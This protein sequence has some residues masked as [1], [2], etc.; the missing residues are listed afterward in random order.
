M[1]YDSRYNNNSTIAVRAMCAIVFCV[2]TFVWLYYFQAD[3][4][5]VGQHV[6]SGGKTHYN[7]L[8]GALLITFVLQLMQQGVYALVRLQ[9]RTHALTYVPSFLVLAILS[10]LAADGGE[11]IKPAVWAWL[12]PL[13]LVLWGVAVWLSRKLLPFESDKGYIGLFSRR[14]WIN[15]LIMAAQIFTAVATT[16]TNAV[17]HFRAHA[18]NSLREGCVDE[19]VRVGKRSL[20]TDSHLTMLRVFALSKQ[21]TLGDRLFEYALSGKS[22]DMLPL[23][24]SQSHLLMLSPDSLWRHLGGIPREGMTVNSYL[25]ALERDSLA[26]KAVGDYRLCGCLIDKRIDN[27]VRLLPRYYNV[28]DTLVVDRLPK[29]Y[30]EALTLYRHLRAN[31]VLVY[32]NNVLEEDYAD[33]QKLGKRYKKTSERHLRVFDRYH[34]TYWYYYFYKK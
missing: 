28:G 5:A 18:E 7:R 10:D 22:T 3:V 6:L 1:S 25:D 21:G 29:H 12:L 34:G 33:F 16:N 30:R 26:T 2:F 17:Y 19:A 14:M 31:P 27:F 15:M 32:Q 11:G 9:R 20:E 8:V 4:L 23:T 24:D 13:L